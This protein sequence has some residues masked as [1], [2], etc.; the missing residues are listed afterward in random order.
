MSAGHTAAVAGVAT[1]AYGSFPETDA[2]GLARQALMDALSDAGLQRADVDG[3]ITCRV[4]SHTRFSE[5]A[6]INPNFVLEIPPYGRLTGVAI[7][8]AVDAVLAGHVEVVALAYGNNGRSRRVQYGGGDAD[9]AVEQR[10]WHA[11]GMTSPGAQHALLFRRHSALYGTTTQQLGHISVTFRD[12]A[13]RNDSAVMRKTITLEDHEN[14]RFIVEP[15]RLLD[16]CLINDGG[17][18]LVITTSERARAC[19]K[20]PVEV[21]AAAT[22]GNFSQA[23]FPPEDFWHAPLAACA[24]ESFGAAGITREDVDTAQI[25]DNFT[26]TV[27]FTLEGLGFCARG[28]GGFFVEDGALSLGG[29]LPTNTSGGHLSESYMQGWALN[30]EAVRQLRGE[31]RNRQVPNCRIAQYAAAAPISSS[32]IYGTA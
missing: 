8:A 20:P 5:I 13:S 3:L 18:A 12:H 6:G 14:S 29:R 31:A 19:R 25:Y 4:P 11:W 17:V 1:T 32:I 22:K 23:S 24:A 9:V 7:K 21:L 15:L 16:Y 26:P 2:M 28:E 10:L 27:I 30:V